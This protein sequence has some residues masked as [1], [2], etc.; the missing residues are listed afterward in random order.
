MAENPVTY[1]RLDKVLRQMGFSSHVVLG[2]VK[3]RVYK[4]QGTGALIAIAYLPES[5]AVLPLHLNAVR[6]TL[7]E[8]A[9]ANPLELA[10]QLQP[11]G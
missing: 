2:D 10:A 6:A 5:D 3:T 1:A 9:I 11:A 4:H 7:N 8:Y